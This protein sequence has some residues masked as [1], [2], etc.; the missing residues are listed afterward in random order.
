MN[1]IVSLL[2]SFRSVAPF[3]DRDSDSNAQGLLPPYQLSLYTLHPVLVN[4]AHS[5]LNYL[6]LILIFGF[7]LEVSL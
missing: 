4:L 1:L 6:V 2:R 5:T 7:L 3:D